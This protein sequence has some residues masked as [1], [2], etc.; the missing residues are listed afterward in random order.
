[1]VIL[2]LQRTMANLAP[3]DRHRVSD[4]AVPP[5]V[6]NMDIPRPDRAKKK[7]QRRLIIGGLAG[8]LLVAISIGVSQ[9]RPAA[10]TVER[11][12]VWID[13]VKRGPML[14]QVRGLG[15]LVAEDVVQIASQFDGRVEKRLVLPGER[16]RPD[17]ILLV[18]S[19]PDMELS[20]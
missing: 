19:N 3:G 18:L 12:A 4:G 7:N 8:F 14:R 15:T 16:V 2:P 9:L 20:A 13:T 1:M 6:S 10:P 11:S 5:I 17:T